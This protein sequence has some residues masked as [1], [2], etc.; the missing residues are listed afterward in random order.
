M[1]AL[2]LFM[3]KERHISGLSGGMER[4]V[5]EGSLPRGGET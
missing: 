4:S 3:K 5:K 1:R 2:C